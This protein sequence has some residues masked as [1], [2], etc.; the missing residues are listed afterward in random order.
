[1]IKADANKFANNNKSKSNI[2]GN[3]LRIMTEK[4]VEDLGIDDSCLDKYNLPNLHNMISFLHGIA[5][6]KYETS[7]KPLHKLSC[8]DIYNYKQAIAFLFIKTGLTENI[9]LTN[10][11]EL[12]AQ[13]TSSGNMI[14]EIQFESLIHNFTY[15]WKVKKFNALKVRLSLWQKPFI[16]VGNN[17]ISPLSILARFSNLYT[18][19]ESVLRNFKP[20]NG[21]K[22]ENILTEC[23]KDQVWQTSTCPNKQEHGDVDVVMEDESHIVYMQLK[24]T[25]QKLNI[26]ELHLQK[27]QDNKAIKQLNEAAIAYRGIKKLHLWYVTTAFEK[28]GT[29]ECNVRRVSYQDLLHIKRLLDSEFK[30]FESLNDFI[31]MVETDRLYKHFKENCT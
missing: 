27:K 14:P 18:I 19:T 12:H 17:I 30:R 11:K 10:K 15:N 20:K 6:R 22:I 21:T 31:E 9:L 4:V 24:R 29:F 28:V 3:T 26:E 25:S 7:L 16:K 13:A 23:F 8:S 1:L 5:Y 2:H